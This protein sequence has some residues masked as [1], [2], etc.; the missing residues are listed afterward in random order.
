MHMQT[1]YEPKAIR[2]L[3]DEM[4]ATYGVVNLISSFGFSAR[5]RHEVVRGLAFGGLARVVDL[6]SGM[7]SAC[8]MR[9]SKFRR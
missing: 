8:E 9:A 6:M 3:F 2:A 1:Q 7:P 4:S 5:W